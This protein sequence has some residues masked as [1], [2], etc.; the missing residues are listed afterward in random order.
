MNLDLPTAIVLSVFV[1]GV[2]AVIITWIIT[3]NT[4]T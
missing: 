2:C 3:A 1:I 4:S